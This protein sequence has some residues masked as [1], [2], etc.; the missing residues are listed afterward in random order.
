MRIRLF[1]PRDTVLNSRIEHYA[2][3][4]AMESNAQVYAGRDPRELAESYA[5]EGNPQVYVALGRVRQQGGHPTRTTRQ[6]ERETAARAE[7]SRAARMRA[8]DATPI[9]GDIPNFWTN[10]ANGTGGPAET[11]RNIRARR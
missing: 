6:W 3:P 7:E 4:R 10:Q 9:P 8:F 1:Q 5:D 2:T 11:A